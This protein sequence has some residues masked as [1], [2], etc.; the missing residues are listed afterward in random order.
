VQEFVDAA[1]EADGDLTFESEAVEARSPG[2]A[3]WQDAGLQLRQFAGKK[4]RLESMGER[5]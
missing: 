4:G 2:H 1:R 5:R 3:L